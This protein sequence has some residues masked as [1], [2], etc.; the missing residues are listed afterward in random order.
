MRVEVQT[1][2]NSIKAIENSILTFRLCTKHKKENILKGIPENSDKRTV[3]KIDDFLK[4]LDLSAQTLKFF[5]DEI[6][7]ILL[8]EVLL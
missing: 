5:K 4:R 6:K 3:L 7:E 8:D 1:I 2:E